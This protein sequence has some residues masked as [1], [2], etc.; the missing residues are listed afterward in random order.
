MGQRVVAHK[1]WKCNFCPEARQDK[2]DM[3]RHLQDAHGIGS[4]ESG[5]TLMLEIK[6]ETKPAGQ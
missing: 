1:A 6:K 3:W 4:V 2:T 5:S